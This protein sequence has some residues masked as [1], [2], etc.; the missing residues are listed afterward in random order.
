MRT[1]R[2][3]DASAG[4]AA[5]LA[6]DA[7]TPLPSPSVHDNDDMVSC[8]SDSDDSD[9]MMSC[10]SEALDDPLISDIDT[11]A[12]GPAQVGDPGMD[13]PKVYGDPGDPAQPFDADAPPGGSRDEEA[14]PM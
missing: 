3:P 5:L 14:T 10:V 11:A 9:D 8:R 6:F 7:L 13:A 12:N 2:A 4:G 1:P